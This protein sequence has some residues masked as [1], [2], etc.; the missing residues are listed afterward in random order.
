M[1]YYKNILIF[2]L[3][4]FSLSIIAQD[5]TQDS[6]EDNS[7]NTQTTTTNKVGIGVT[8]PTH[9]LELPLNQ[10][11][12]FGNR[13]F[14]GARTGTTG[15]IS[16]NA[17]VQNGWKIADASAKAT[18]IELR[19]N[20]AIEM[21]GTTTN[22]TA[23]WRKMF[24]FNAPAN[25]VY[26]PS[27][28]VGIGTSSPNSKLNIVGN[29]GQFRLYS[30]K[31][32]GHSWIGFYTDGNPGSPRAAW[33]GYGNDGHLNF[34]LKNEK[35]GGD[36]VF[37]PNQNVG[38][39]TTNPTSKLH[40]G[41]TIKAGNYANETLEIGHGGAHG[42]INNIGDGNID[43]RHEGS[44]KAS[45]LSNGVFRVNK[46]EPLRGDLYLSGRAWGMVF[47]INTD[48]NGNNKYD[49]QAGGNTMMTLDSNRKMVLGTPG[50]DDAEFITN[51]TIYAREVI[52]DNQLPTPDYVFEKNYQ[53]LSIEEKAA[54]TVEQK[55]LP[56]VKSAKEMEK[57][58][59]VLELN[60]A[61]LQELEEAY[62]YI[63]Q[64]NQQIKDQQ[65]QIEE[66]KA[67][68]NKL[69]E[70]QQQILQALETMK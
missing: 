64:M 61:M 67:I 56:N 46:M 63:F 4:L 8:N 55:H 13:L 58:V 29:G 47:Q 3:V 21:Y 66:Q 40:V 59:N 25:T 33:M 19:N 53:M 43:F 23:S 45:I 49:W 28:K 38:I 6:W 26:F 34:T 14:I 9:Q 50:S 10:N 12:S 62:K 11:T 15:S 41:G 65:T 39:N 7:T 57:G 5:T 1:I 51:G 17:Y 36:I 20:G 16:R 60:Y 69:A 24:G 2:S 52:V 35:S 30:G 27:G 31:N 22:G 42:Y 48:G 68:N 18:T 54:Y 70:T 44:T 37:L 32:N